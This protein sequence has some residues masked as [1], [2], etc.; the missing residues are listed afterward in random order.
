MSDFLGDITQRRTSSN[1][2]GEHRLVKIGPKGQL[3]ASFYNKQ[4][5][6]QLTFSPTNLFELVHLLIF[7][8]YLIYKQLARMCGVRAVGVRA[9]DCWQ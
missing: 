7:C 5:A 9:V 8:L 1:V 6:H 4:F 2:A 3:K